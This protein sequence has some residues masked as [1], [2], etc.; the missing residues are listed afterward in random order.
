MDTS[1]GTTHVGELSGVLFHVGTLDR[2]LNQGAIVHLDRDGTLKRDGL[3][4]L[5]DLVVLG[6]VGVEVVLPGKA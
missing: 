6:K 3:V 5:A 1:G 2:D 4:V